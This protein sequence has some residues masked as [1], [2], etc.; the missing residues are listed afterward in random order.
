[1]PVVTPGT[2]SLPTGEYGQFKYY[3]TGLSKRCCAV[4]LMFSP[5]GYGIFSGQETLPTDIDTAGAVYRAM[6]KYINVKG[7][8]ETGALVKLT[9]DASDTGGG[10]YDLANYAKMIDANFGLPVVKIMDDLGEVTDSIAMAVGRAELKTLLERGD[11]REYEF[12]AE[13]AT[14][15]LPF[16][17][18][19]MH[20]GFIGVCVAVSLAMSGGKETVNV[21]LVDLS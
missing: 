5:G 11:T 13:L 15:P 7:K 10:L 4:T 18:V 17:T 14:L 3:A 1:M 8:S 16:Q 6:V 12:D 21:T 20:D 19:E 9:N 2:D